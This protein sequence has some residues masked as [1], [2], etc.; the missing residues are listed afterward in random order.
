M[1]WQGCGKKCVYELSVKI[2][3]KNL[4]QNYEENFGRKVFW[5]FLVTNLL[6][7]LSGKIVLME[8]VKNTV[9]NCVEKWFSRSGWKIWWEKCVKKLYGKKIDDQFGWQVYVKLSW[10]KLGVKFV[11]IIWLTHFVESWVDN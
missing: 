6:K 7:E 8:R 11:E 3:R 2:S 4:V 9:E 10:N 1:D 5:I